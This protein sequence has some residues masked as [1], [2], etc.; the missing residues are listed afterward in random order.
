MIGAPSLETTLSKPAKNYINVSYSILGWV[1]PTDH[2]RIAWL[3]LLTI[4]LFAALGGATA[5]LLRLELLTPEADLMMTD[6]F[7]RVFTMHGT[8]MVYLFILPAMLGVL[9]SFLLPLVIGARNMA[10]ARLNLLTF[11]MFA[12]GAMLTILLAAY[13]GIDTGWT[14]YPPYSTTFSA[15]PAPAG[16][17]LILITMFAMV[18]MSINIFFTIQRR[19]VKGLTW[20]RLPILAWAYYVTSIVVLVGA[21]FGFIAGLLLLL[22]WVGNVG[23]I[24]PTYGGN[25]LLYE[26]L[27]W[28]FARSAVYV[29]I[30]PAIG[31]VSE[32]IAAFTKKP[33]FGYKGIV[34]SIIALAVLMLLS[35]GSNIFPSDQS[36]FVTLLF[37]FLS[38]LM[39]APLVVILLSWAASFKNSQTTWSA[40]LLFAM[41]V[42]IFMLRSVM[43]D[44]VL[45]SPVTGSYLSG[46]TFESS[47]FH[48]LM[49]GV[50]TTAFLSAMHF[51]WPKITGRMYSN[52]WAK[53]AALVVLVG[54]FMAFAPGCLLGLAGM[55]SRIN[56]YPEEFM[57]LNQVAMLGSLTLG[58]GFTLPLLY[59]I[60][61]LITGKSA[62]SN[63]WE[64]VGLEWQTDSPPPER[65]FTGKSITV[66]EAYAYSSSSS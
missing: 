37:S 47:S 36:I 66:E 16:I 61:S 30:L 46:T 57:F 11:Y 23:I 58:L 22:E 41:V 29:M 64:A 55:R 39:I 40:P 20:M 17:I 13:G 9:G 44:L 52:T 49:V 25:P 38:F 1:F 48:F 14:Y 3:Y 54:V 8:T 32:I 34:Y 62:G 21:L 4:S 12:G 5:M 45:S 56:A 50:V 15:T 65:N 42:I 60:G 63:P 2:K 26:N 6:I 24:D 28:L 35:W 59:F 10:F 18:L 31:I 7:N 27:F 43:S 53:I 33:L 51:W 19:R